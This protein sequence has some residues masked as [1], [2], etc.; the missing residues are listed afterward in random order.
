MSKHSSK[1]AE[2]AEASAKFAHRGVVEGYYGRAYTH[3]DR[4]WL[5]EQMGRWGM[6]R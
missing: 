1:S 5:I 2:S 4:L 6:N 3:A